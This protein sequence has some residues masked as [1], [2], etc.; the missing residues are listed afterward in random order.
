MVYKVDKGAM[1]QYI[2]ARTRIYI[3]KS[4]VGS[5]HHTHGLRLRF[6]HL[7]ARTVFTYMFEFLFCLFHLSLS[8][9][10]SLSLYIYIYIY[11][12]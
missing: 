6:L 8:L 12:I 11:M 10:L 5:W 2:F 1:C 9:S 3:E 7:I 4:E